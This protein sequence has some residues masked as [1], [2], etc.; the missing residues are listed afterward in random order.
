[1]HHWFPLL[2]ILAVPMG[3]M[4][5]ARAQDETDISRQEEVQSLKLRFNRLVRDARKVIDKQGVQAGIEFYNDALLEPEN[6]SFGQIHLRLGNLYKKTGN[7]MDAA[8][9]Y[10]ECHRDERVDQ[11]DREVICQQGFFGVTAVL[12]IEDLPRGAQVVIIEPQAFAGPFKSGARLPKGPVEVMVEAPGR[13]PRGTTVD[14]YRNVVW[15]ALLGLPHQQGPLIPD[16]FVADD[17]PQLDVLLVPADSEKP[18]TGSRRWPAILTAGIGVA[19]V[20]AGVGLGATNQTD[21]IELRNRQRQGFCGFDL[22]NSELPGLEDRARLADGLW[23]GGAVV[24]LAAIA[25]WVIFDE[26]EETG[27]K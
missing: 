22:C 2:V 11:V 27:R 10:R 8:H 12:T 25:L 21:R 7:L 24:Q 1:V 26:D 17:D 20:G 4:G 9:H 15:Q 19:L 23:I 14:L 5:E 6:E 16:G 3:S 18:R 13:L